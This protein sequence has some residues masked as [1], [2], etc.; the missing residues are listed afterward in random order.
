VDAATGETTQIDLEGEILTNGDGLLKLGRW[1]YVV[2]NSLNQVA[3]VKPDPFATAGVIEGYITNEHLDIPTTVTAVGWSLYTVNAR[4]TT[5][6]TPETEYS[7]V[8]LP[9]VP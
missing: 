8:R 9:L 5:E 7:I 6:P 1:L 2:Q 4:F 3:V